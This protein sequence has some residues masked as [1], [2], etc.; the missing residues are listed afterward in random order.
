M[1]KTGRSFVLLLCVMAMLLCVPVTPRAAE[2]Q[3][4]DLAAMKIVLPDEA[5]AVELTAANELQH[6]IGMITGKSNTIVKEKEASG[7]GIYVG[8]T[9][10]AKEK[11]VTYPTENDSNGEAWAIQ[12]VGSDLVLCGAEQRGTLYAVYHLLEDVLGVRWWNPWE[13]YVPSGDAIVPYDYASSGVPAMEYREAYIGG[14]SGQNPEFFARNR[15]NGHHMNIQASYGGSEVYGRPAHVHTFNRYF[16]TADYNAHPEWFSLDE[17]GQRVSDRQLCLSNQ[18]LRREFAKRLIANVKENPEATYAV[19]PNDNKHFCECFECQNAIDAYGASGYVL[20]FVNEMA[21]AVAKA[22]YPETSIEML[23][24][25]M[26][27]NEPAGDIV[28]E[29]N[30]TIRFAD[31]YTDLLHSVNHLNNA[32][33]MRNLKIWRDISSNDFYYWQYVVNYYNNGIVPSMFHYGEDFTTLYE[34]GVNGWFAEQEQCI[35]V[36]FWDMKLWLLTK[37]MEN[38]VSGEEYEALMDEFIFGYYGEEPGKYIREYLY[39]MHEKAELNPNAQ[40]FGTHIIEVDWLDVEDIIHGNDLF[41]K[42]FAAAEDDNLL[43]RRLRC[44]RNGFDRVAYENFS[45]WQKQAEKRDLELPFTQRELGERICYAFAEQI[46]L[47]GGYDADYMSFYTLYDQYTD[48]LPELPEALGNVDREHIWE[49]TV[50][51]Y[52]LTE[53]YAVVSD[54]DS[55]L[56]KTVRSDASG[57]EAQ[58]LEGG[59]TVIIALYNPNGGGEKVTVINRI[60][61]ADILDGDG[62]QLYRCSFTVPT[63]G[64]G[65]YVY[66]YNDWG[67]QIPQ[68]ATT[69]RELEGRTVEI[70]V[71][72]KVDGKAFSIDRVLILPE[73]D[74]RAHHYV[75]D[76]EKGRSVCDICGDVLLFEPQGTGDNTG[77]QQVP[78]NMGQVMLMMAGSAFFEV[79]GFGLLMFWML[80]KKRRR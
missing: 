11:G 71:S 67:L 6:Y 36:D 27:V 51:D 18:G 4:L 22:G 50:D 47:R 49:F 72:M 23:V 79:V 63:I 75:N 59:D 38:P 39:Y 1:R 28:P 64:K 25:W 31:N 10:F 32:N 42:A 80:R 66:I 54:E 7:T 78:E 70:V 8:N 45:T 30:V 60:T 58:M 73:E 37:L 41:D 16:S 26:Y 61:L 24:Y 56:G 52:R 9:N 76:Y 12:A 14:Q 53:N 5:T 20:H 29:P 77:T 74:Q 55:L 40:T 13:E 33:S 65:G 48:S 69:L 68:M 21:R 35:N 43:L 44:A 34:L 46:H 3:G 15:I 2:A 17:N 57:R 19:C 62:Y